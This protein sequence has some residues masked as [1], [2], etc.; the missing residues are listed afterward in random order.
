MIVIYADY[1]PS[2]IQQQH[3]WIEL[4]GRIDCW[5]LIGIQR[6]ILRFTLNDYE[7]DVK[8]MNTIFPLLNMTHEC[9]PIN[10]NS[11][12]LLKTIL[13]FY[14]IKDNYI[15]IQQLDVLSVCCM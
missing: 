11:H 4:K 6:K 3:Q 1:M 9:I 14:S 13:K 10:L 15:S 7:N 12:I 5:S 8:S 2:S